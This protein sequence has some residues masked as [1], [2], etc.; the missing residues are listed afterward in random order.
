MQ[1]SLNFHPV[2]GS[3]ELLNFVNRQRSVNV[4]KPLFGFLERPP[5]HI[6]RVGRSSLGVASFDSENVNVREGLLLGGVDDATSAFAI[7]GETE[8]VAQNS[9]DFVSDSSLFNRFIHKSQCASRFRLCQNQ[10][11]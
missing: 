10:S 9:N 11:K 8:V 7:D 5:I 3:V 4:I 6:V 1:S 2:S